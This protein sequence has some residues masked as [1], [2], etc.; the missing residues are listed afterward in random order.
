MRVLVGD[1]RPAAA[2]AAVCYVRSHMEHEE[3]EEGGGRWKVVEAKWRSCAAEK[4]R[5]KNVTILTRQG[6]F[7]LKHT[8]ISLKIPVT[9]ARQ[10]VKGQDGRQNQ[11]RPET[12]TANS[13]STASH[14]PPNPLIP[15]R[16]PA[17]FHT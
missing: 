15:A 7:R 2:A 5:V 4:T 17:G 8:K 11:R 1:T 3:L 13:N 16:N 10:A 12:Q 9:A 14:F 6:P